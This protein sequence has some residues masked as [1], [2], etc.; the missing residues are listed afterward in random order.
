MKD[1]NQDGTQAIRRAAAILR[2]ISHVSGDA[3]RN[4]RAISEAVGLPRSTTHRILKSLTD[5]GLAAYD[6]AS[7]KYEVGMLSYELGL[8]VSDRVLALAPWTACVDRVAERSNVTTYLMRRSGFEAVCMHKAEG[9]A[10]IRVIPVEVGQRRYLGVGAGATA[11]LAGLP[12]ETVERVIGTIA[13]EL[14]GFENLD[15]D[16]VRQAV[17]TTRETGFSESRGRAYRSIFGMGMGVCAF[18]EEPDLAIS[19]AVHSDEVDEGRIADWKAI[20]REE[21]GETQARIAAA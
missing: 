3:P 7:R 21:I 16:S 1:E 10:V 20:L 9:R 15:A 14:G 11:L 12:D 17:A 2:Q 19:I 13:P 8:A 18:A 6:T 5:T 4:L